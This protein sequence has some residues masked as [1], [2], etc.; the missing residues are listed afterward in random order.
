[1]AEIASTDGAFIVVFA[2]APAAPVETAV[3]RVFDM[4]FV[5]NVEF[6]QQG[7][8]H[9]LLRSAQW[10]APGNLMMALAQPP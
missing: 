6:A 7:I 1:M 8:Q 2:A 4:P 9:D 10:P 5:S 3:V